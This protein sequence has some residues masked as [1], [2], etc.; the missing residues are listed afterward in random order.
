[1]I[2]EIGKTQPIERHTR[3]TARDEKGP[4]GAH[5]YYLIEPLNKQKAALS[6]VFA[7]VKFQQGPIVEEGV[8]GCTNEDLLTV[9]LHRLE[10]FQ[11]GS[12]PCAENDNAAVHIRVALH[13]LHERT[14]QRMWQG[15]EGTNQHRR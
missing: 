3:I 11:A 15:I 2:T 1:M 6:P 10:C 7:Q 5:H 4:G 9:V 8:N 13:I 12:H 14:R